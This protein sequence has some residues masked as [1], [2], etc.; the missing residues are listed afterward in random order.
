MGTEGKRGQSA[1]LQG[2]ASSWGLPKEGEEKQEQLEVEQD[3]SMPRHQI[4][5]DFSERRHVQPW[6]DAERTLAWSLTGNRYT[7]GFL[8]SWG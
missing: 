2:L 3:G 7:Q 4:S 5:R 8:E 6:R 1:V